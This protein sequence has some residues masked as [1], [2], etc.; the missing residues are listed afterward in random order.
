MPSSLL[1]YRYRIKDATSG[2][3]L[4][5]MAWAVNTAWNYCQ[6]VSLLAL[7]REKRWMTA[8]D[9]INLC[10]GASQDLGISSETI[11]E[12]C[13]EY[14]KKRR[15]FRKRRLKWRSR[16]RSLGWIPLKMRFLKVQGDT[17]RYQKRRFRFWNSRPIQGIPKTGSFS[18]DAQG[19]WYLNIQCEVADPGEP[20]GTTE[21]GI[22]LGC[23][24]QIACSDIEEPYTRSNLTR[25]YEDR[26]A[27]AQ[28][29]H[30]KRRVTAL[31]AKI[32]NIRRD[33]THKVTT[34]IVTRASFLAIGDVSSTKLAK[35]PLA[36]SIYDAAWGIARGCLRYKAI[37]LG[38]PVTEPHEFRSSL[39]CAD[40][41]AETG[42]RG[43]RGLGV[44]VWTCANCGKTH[45]RDHN[46]ARNHLRLGRE[47]L[48][49]NPPT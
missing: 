18:Q 9:L 4:L 27:M 17:I 40:C 35:T 6:E 31:H 46:S 16:K 15:Q 28:R 5:R 48:L 49:R 29:A 44:R 7:Q 47:A 13:R 24:D 30:K 25:L 37:R 45:Q 22:D 38:I 10:A 21:I 33:W 32:A 11:A 12:V 23:M 2:T 43:L 14:V 20:I 42:P 26:L 1:T 3:H 8:V 36:K 39:T 19:R 34:E 41:L